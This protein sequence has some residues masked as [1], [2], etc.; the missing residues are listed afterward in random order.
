M[1]KNPTKIPAKCSYC[2][3]DFLAIVSE[4]K[5][6]RGKFCSLLCGNRA[7]ASARKNPNWKAEWLLRSKSDPMHKIK[8]YARGVVENEIKYGRLVR[9]PCEVCGLLKSEAHHDDYTKPLD[10]R[11]LCRSHHMKQDRN[12]K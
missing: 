7:K 11:W 9:K 3:K 10:V 1:S 8:R 2:L 4:V 12:P 6:R 5:R